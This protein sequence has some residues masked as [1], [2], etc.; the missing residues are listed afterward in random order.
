MAW[1]EPVTWVAIQLVDADDLNEQI[2]GNL[3]YLYDNLPIRAS[4]FHDTSLPTSG[5]S[6]ITAITT[7]QPYNH[8]AYQTTAADGNS[9]TQSF[10][11]AEGTYT[12]SILGQTRGDAGM[13]D[14]YV[15][16]VVVGAGQDWYSGGVVSNV[17]K[18]VA[19]IVIVESGRHVLTGVINGK[20]ASSSNYT[21]RL[22]KMWFSPA[23]D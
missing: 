12:L 16:G 4:M 17:V 6:I 1:T 8:T 9:F 7:T 15:D 22:T 10:V 13:V 19:D 14:W 11:L 5:D 21:L 2:S 23:A 3:A 18:T 20:H